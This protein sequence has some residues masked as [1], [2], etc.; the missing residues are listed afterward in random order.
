MNESIDANKE[1]TNE[2]TGLSDKDQAEIDALLDA[3]DELFA[4]IETANGLKKQKPP[5][6]SPPRGWVQF[7]FD[8]K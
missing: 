7:C 1:A 4:E 2:H 8:R 6:P 3:A 5:P